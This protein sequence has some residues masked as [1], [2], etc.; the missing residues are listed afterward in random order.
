MIE[1]YNHIWLKDLFNILHLQYFHISLYK[2][3][4]AAFK[5]SNIGSCFNKNFIFLQYN[6]DSL[7][8]ISLG[9]LVW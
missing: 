1:G 3:S 7:K 6:L 5:N 2:N 9:N 8:D 4:C